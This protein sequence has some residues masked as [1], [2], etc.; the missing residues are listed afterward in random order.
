MRSTLLTTDYFSEYCKSI[1]GDTATSYEREKPGYLNLEDT[2]VTNG[3]EDPW[4]WASVRE[5][6]GKMQTVLLDC[7]QCAHTTDFR[8]CLN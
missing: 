2:L 8:L 7:D 1:F 6:V 3:H 4:Q 5:D